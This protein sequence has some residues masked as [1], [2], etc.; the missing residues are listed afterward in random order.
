MTLVTPSSDKKI[1]FCEK[2]LYGSR[3]SLAVLA[4]AIDQCICFYVKQEAQKS[5]IVYLVCKKLIFKT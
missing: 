4:S 3:S 2:K 1:E 5:L